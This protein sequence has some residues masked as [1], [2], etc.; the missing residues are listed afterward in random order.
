[1]ATA[2]V[3]ARP[4]RPAPPFPPPSGTVINVSS[5]SELQA[6]VGGIAS[7]TTIVIAPG[8]YHLTR[9][10]YFNG[11]LANIGL[12]GA[13]GD[14]EDVVLI[15]PGMTQPAYG[16][17]PYGIWTGGGVDGITIANLTIRDFYYHPI[18]FNGGTQRPHVYNVHLI[19]AGQQFIKSNPDD[20]GIGA[21]DGIVEYSIF[22]FTTTARDDYPKGV[23]VHGG[24]NWQIRPNLF[25][26]LQAPAGLLIGPAVLVWHGSSNTV[27]EGNLFLNCGR[28]IMYGAE[29]A[30]GLAH[31]G[32][33]IRNNVFYRSSTQ[34][35]DVGVQVADSPDT[36][37]L[38]NTILLSG[39][40][41]AAIEYR[42]P[43]ASGLLIANNLLDSDIWARDGATAT[44]QA[45]V[46]SA[47][48][49]LFV[50]PGGGDLHLQESADAAIDHG[51]VV[52]AVS[53]DWDGDARPAGLGV[54]V[55][56][57]EY[58]A[59]PVTRQI[60]GHVRA[61]ATNV[62]VAGVT[63]TLSGAAS[64]THTTDADGAYVFPSLI[65][66]ANYRVTATLEGFTFTPSTQYYLP[67]AGDQL[68]TDFLGA[69]I[70]TANQS[71]S[72]GLAASAA[73]LVAG[74]R[75]LL[76]AIASDPD[77]SVA[78]VTL[79][80]DQKPLGK[81]AAVPYSMSWRAAKA[82][83]HT[84]VAIATDDAGAT[85]PSEPVTVVVRAKTRR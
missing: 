71:P 24:A 82:G 37:V 54:D 73:S 30:P 18:I 21:S 25:R 47:T 59:T 68:A 84:F 57:D 17:V 4:A 50:N 36:Q 43:G 46:T 55:G 23:D 38:N 39:T 44:L 80:V 76:T 49:S 78:G 52:S 22:E 63:I 48:P 79:Y 10:L 26:N 28:G 11:A 64:G 33:V 3:D 5:E 65:D 1:M 45:N 77:G 58:V 40:Y 16:S 31:L 72:I 32:G 66:G 27:T 85:T 69:S 2:S 15:G 19:D 56:A 75:L 29:D 61:I 53:D 51:I 7:N 12:R 83:T 6:A 60:A 67:L 81:D 70:P 14:S 13:T 8:T 9:T 35:G 20:S 34:G 42:Y 41:R 74:D 62:P